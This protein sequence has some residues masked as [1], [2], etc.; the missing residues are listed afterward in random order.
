MRF[1]HISDLHLGWYPKAI[2]IN[3][4]RVK[5]SYRGLRREINRI[6]FKNL[7]Y[8]IRYA[9]DNG[10]ELILIAGDIFENVD[11]S[12]IYTRKL[13]EY[14]GEAVGNGINILM[15]AGNHDAYMPQ[16]KR[17]SLSVFSSKVS[18]RIRYVD[19]LSPEMLTRGEEMVINLDNAGL[20][21][22]PLPYFHI[23]GLG[24]GW[25]RLVRKYVED[26]VQSS[27]YPI[28]VLLGHVQLERVR[29]TSM[30]RDSSEEAVMLPSLTLTDIRH[31][32]FDYV[33]LGHIHLM[34][35]VGS[36]HV[37]YSGSLNR[38]R[39]DEALDEKYF[40]DV[41][42]SN[43]RPRVQP[44]KVDPIKMYYVKVEYH[45]YTDIE[46]IENYI[47][48][49]VGDLEGS[50]VKI[51]FII[52]EV[53][54]SSFT[55]IWDRLRTRIIK[56]LWDNGVLAA[57]LDKVILKTEVS[58]TTSTEIS[59]ERIDIK[60]YLKRYIEERFR[61]LDDKSRDRVFEKALEYLEK[62]VSQ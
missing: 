49:S 43:N 61:D 17:A 36:E 16:L 6:T 37:Y 34:Q 55:A 40:L 21:I 1:L 25:R 31:D 59:M 24:D 39:F 45:K 32:L 26:A 50:L 47:L 46:S 18:D 13:A 22:V 19:V 33:A 51:R 54:Y 60:S 10:I 44:I 48:A 35:S 38:L 58:S 30:Y 15:I 29:F 23:G 2:N 62:E 57:K 28:R 14:L 53:D 41:S 12:L 5:D 8:A 56:T 4:H 11:Q 7:E 27:S 42:I 20:S 52:R 3:P 9:E